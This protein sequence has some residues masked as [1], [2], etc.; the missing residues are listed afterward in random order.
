ME[1]YTRTSCSGFVGRLENHPCHVKWAYAPLATH[2]G[3]K[4]T[5]TCQ[6]ACALR[7]TQASVYVRRTH[8]K[9][10]KLRLKTGA[11]GHEEANDT[12][13]R[14]VSSLTRAPSLSKRN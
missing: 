4:S 13:M 10:D 9:R 14:P 3:D 2:S 12:L 11:P 5:A 8:A 1:S 7:G 6:P